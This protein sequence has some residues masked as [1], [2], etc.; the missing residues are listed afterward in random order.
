MIA[1]PIGGGL[2][3]PY[4]SITIVVSLILNGSC[5]VITAV[6]SCFLKIVD[7]YGLFLI[8]VFLEY[9]SLNKLLRSEEE[10]LDEKK[11]LEVINFTN[12]LLF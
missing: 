7:P 10:S 6:R 1:I 9:F 8:K 3:G 4:P 11:F 2:F 5:S 12:A